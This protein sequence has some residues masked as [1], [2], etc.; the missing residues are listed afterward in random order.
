MKPSP[1]YLLKT[2]VQ[3]WTKNISVRIQLQQHKLRKYVYQKQDTES[4]HFSHWKYLFLKILTNPSAW[5]T[6]TAETDTFLWDQ[7]ITQKLF[8]RLMNEGK[9]QQNE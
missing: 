4:I 7:D 3:S 2:L 9:A 6:A 5:G 1:D 8:A